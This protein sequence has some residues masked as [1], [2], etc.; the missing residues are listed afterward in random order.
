MNRLAIGPDN[1]AAFALM[2]GTK[3]VL[4]TVSELET[5]ALPL[6]TSGPLIRTLPVIVTFPV[7]TEG[8]VTFRA[9]ATLAVPTEKVPGADKVFEISRFGP[10]MIWLF[11]RATG[12]MLNPCAGFVPAD[13]LMD[14][15]TY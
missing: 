2:V 8:P 12:L 3:M 7:S 4:P 10:L 11:P 13:R 14:P 6:L 9:F 5:N 1:V 15:P